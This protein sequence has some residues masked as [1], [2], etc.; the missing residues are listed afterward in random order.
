MFGKLAISGDNDDKK[1]KLGSGDRVWDTEYNGIRSVAIYGRFFIY[2]S[3]LFVG[4]SHLADS[5]KLMPLYSSK[6]T[7]K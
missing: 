5:T 2:E 3:L 4:S 1:S 7:I 6:N